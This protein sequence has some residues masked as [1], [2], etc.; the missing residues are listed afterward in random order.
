MACLPLEGDFGVHEFRAAVA[1]DA[2]LLAGGRAATAAGHPLEMD[3]AAGRGGALDGLD[4]ADVD[5]PLLAGGLRV[6]AG[7][8]AV[9]EV[10]QF[11]GDLV[12]LAE[13][14]AVR[15]ALA[16]DL[17]AAGLGVLVGAVEADVA[18]CA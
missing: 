9:G 4:D 13:A 12:D 15:S 10:H 16:A 7:A 3:A 5:E 6:A 14:L 1:A 17:E 18:P 8:H 11:R 2:H